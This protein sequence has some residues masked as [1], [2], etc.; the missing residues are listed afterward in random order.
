MIQT[1]TNPAIE[2]LLDQ[3]TDLELKVSVDRVEENELVVIGPLGERICVDLSPGK[4]S[5]IEQVLQKLV[6]HFKELPLLTIGE[7]KEIRLLTPKISLARLIPTVYSFTH[8]R[9]GEAPGTDL[10]RARFSAEI[11][12]TV[13]CQPGY[14]FLSTAFIGLIESL[15]GPLLAEHVVDPG[16][17]EVR[18]KRYHIGSPLHRYLYTERYPTKSNGPSLVRWSRFIDPVICFDWRH[19]LKDEEGKWLADEPLS[20]DYAGVWIDNIVRAKQ[21]AKHMF[22]WLEYLFA[23]K[24][25]LL[26]DIC[27]FIDKTGTVI[28]GEI[29]PDCMR[30]RSGAADDAESLD[31]DQ[32]RLGHNASDVLDHYTKLYNILF[33]P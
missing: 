10:I 20:D 15:E 6:I 28:F 32:W 1:V 19:P 14:H 7:S 18:V 2:L 12:R 26:I 4:C 13:A 27:F 25:L 30:V 23:S 11:F 5:M 22:E 16:N 8:N 31:K 17:I 29:S 24:G 9:Y 21:L 3:C 33:K